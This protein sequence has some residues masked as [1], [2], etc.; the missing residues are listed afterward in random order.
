MRLPGFCLLILLMCASLPLSV[1]GAVLYKSYVVR[2]DRGTDILCDPYV[3]QKNDYVLKLFEERGE[4]SER[5]FPEFLDIFRRLNPG[6]RNVNRILPGQ[7]ILIPLKKLYQDALPGQASGVVTIPFVTLSDVGELLKEYSSHHRVRRGDSVSVLIARRFGDFGTRSYEDGIRLFRS[8]NPGVKNLNHIYLG[9]LLNLPNP[10]IRKETWFPSLLNDSGRLTNQIALNDLIMGD[11]KVGKPTPSPIPKADEP[12]TGFSRAA[13]ILG[14]KLMAKGKYYFPGEGGQDLALDLAE[15]PVM[16]LT[17]GTRI[18][19]T[20]GEPFPDSDLETIRRYWRRMT[21][22]PLSPETAYG[23]VLDAVL[24][25]MKLPIARNRLSIADDGL[26][27]EIRARWVFEEPA[28]DG[29][30]PRHICVTPIRTRDERTPEPVVRFLAGRKVIV[31]EILPDREDVRQ[32]PSEAIDAQASDEDIALDVSDQ[33]SFVADLL[34]ALR[35]SYSP[36][37]QITF[38]YAGIQVK[39]VS[40]IILKPDGNPLLV[41]FGDFYGEAALALT[42]AGFGIV[43]IEKAD[44]YMEVT[45]KLLRAL[46]VPFHENRTFAAAERPEGDNISLTVSGFFIPEARAS[47]VLISARLLP[48]EL[49][50]FFKSRGIAI[51]RVGGD[52]PGGMKP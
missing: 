25:A 32:E 24:K 18:V 46:G 15:S 44:P 22:A 48:G 52:M 23:S 47:K 3:V 19:F 26:S 38:P 42:K 10:S 21:V 5:D 17:D 1:Y 16:Q 14:A 37:G 6:I 45:K 35:Y 43:R 4:I 12:A 31:K 9:Q 29:T 7:H 49:I 50:R 41:D 33:R 11:G 8:M 13:T 2:Q 30:S 20:R 51:L 27:V 40:N 34:G 39:A 36:D 28:P